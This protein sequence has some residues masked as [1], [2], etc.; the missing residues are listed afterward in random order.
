MDS[1]GSATAKWSPRAAPRYIAPGTTASLLVSW[2]S[3]LESYT[4]INCQLS[5]SA[6]EVLDLSE[7]ATREYVGTGGSGWLARNACRSVR[8]RLLNAAPISPWHSPRLSIWVQR[9]ACAGITS[10]IGEPP[11]APATVMNAATIELI[12]GS[13]AMATWTSG[14]PLLYPRRMYFRSSSF[15]WSLRYCAMLFP[16]VSLLWLGA[17]TSAAGMLNL[18]CR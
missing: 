7:I 13:C 15:Q 2:L 12:S 17:G 10:A 3:C 14:A 8:P 18:S 16:F 1:K 6:L 4:D 11:T 9:W 5:S